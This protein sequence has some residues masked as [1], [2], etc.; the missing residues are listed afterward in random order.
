MDLPDLRREVL[1]LR[2]RIEWLVALLRI[3]VVL[4]KVS[5]FSLA[6]ARLP[7]AVCWSSDIC[8]VDLATSKGSNGEISRQ[9]GT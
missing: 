9:I 5:G 2:K 4:S 1:A 7:D 3:V 6:C 8:A